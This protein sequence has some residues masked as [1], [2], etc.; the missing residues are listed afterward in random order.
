MIKKRRIKPVIAWLI[1]PTDRR[2]LPKKDGVGYLTM[3]K[4]A[5]LGLGFIPDGYEIT[6]VKVTEV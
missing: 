1:V 6:K 2:G 4:K 5:M 3:S